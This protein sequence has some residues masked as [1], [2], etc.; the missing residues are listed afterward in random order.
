MPIYKANDSP[1]KEL[2]II[3]TGFANL[4]K[5][6]GLGGIPLRKITEISGAFSVGKTTLALA[7]VSQAQKEKINCLWADTEYS[8]DI[9][10]ATALGVDSTKLDLCQERFAEQ[11]LDSIEEWIEAHKSALV[12]LDSVGGLLPRA[13][14]EK[15]AEGKTIGG[16]AK[17]IATFCRKVVPMLAINNVGLI[18]LNHEFIDLMSSKLMTSGG[19]K[20]GYHKSIWIRLK[21][22]NKRVM[23][24]DQQVGDVIEVEIRKNKVAPTLKQ[25]TELTLIYGQGFD[26]QA[27]LMETA[28]EKGVITK[29]GQMYFFAGEKVAR[30]LSGLREKFKDPQFINTISTQLNL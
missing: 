24:G 29:Q 12:V 13:E 20:L 26:K 9:D 18:V 16:Q 25:S 15:G 22:A 19:A 28:L 30:G 3:P 11:T 1:F 7:I 23:K 2:R 17:L 14:A 27:D 10:Y 4:N 21:K 8:W 6:L 5:I